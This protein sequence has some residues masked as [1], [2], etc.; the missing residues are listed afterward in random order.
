MTAAHH[1]KLQRPSG[2]SSAESVTAPGHVVLCEKRFPI[3][4]D[5]GRATRLVTLASSLRALGSRVTIFVCEGQS[6]TLEDGTRIR[7][8]PPMPWPL[9]ELV[10]WQ[11]LRRTHRED[12]VDAF[13]VQNDVFVLVALLARLSGF[14]VLYDAQV[15]ERDY[16]SAA[17]DP[18][19]RGAVSRIVMP[20]CERLLCRISDRV[21]VLSDHDAARIREIHGLR[22]E[23]VFI[24]P[25]S[26]RRIKET[27]GPVDV[28]PGPPVVLFLGA[29]VHRPN[30]EAIQLIAREI[31]PRVLR[32]VPDAVF[33]IVGKGLPAADLK[34]QGLEPHS[35]VD[36]VAPFVDAATVCVAPVRVGS[37][38]RTKLLEYLSRGRPVVAMTPALEGL[39]V[40]P[41]VDLLVADDLDAFAED[42]VAL[43]R[44]PAL[45][46]RIGR[47]GLDRIR[48][49]AGRDVAERTLTAFYAEPS[50]P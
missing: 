21:S 30:V 41:G 28:T 26:A 48:E 37:G 12:P 50:R 36:E 45:R 6:T 2:T 49:L 43:L 32:A 22:P 23:N 4:P 18:S 10:L 14:R 9:R 31:R 15:V 35:D 40:R 1:E 19:L 20:V 42:V 44:D 29:Y 17:R 5:H 34:A 8:V 38:V 27:P 47:A 3:P 24:V 39:E 11:E 46:E 13:Q 7:T 16:W 33:Q 25:F